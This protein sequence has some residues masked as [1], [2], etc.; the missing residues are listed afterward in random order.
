MNDKD[1]EWVT[2]K[3]AKALDRHNISTRPLDEAV[4]LLTLSAHG[5]LSRWCEPVPIRTL[6]R[7]IHRELFSGALP[8]S[9]EGMA[10][11]AADVIGRIVNQK[12]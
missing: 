2:A 9:A 4:D 1:H 5:E 11:R 10:R 12:S 3:L 8:A 7:R 6:R